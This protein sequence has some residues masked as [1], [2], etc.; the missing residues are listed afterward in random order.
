MAQSFEAWYASLGIV[1]KACIAM[2]LGTALGITVG[3]VNVYSLLL[4][5]SAITSFQVWRFFTAA[6]FFGG[7]SFQ[8]LMTV[9]SFISF[10]RYNEESSFKGKPAD[11]ALAIVFVILVIGLL[12][13]YMGLPV[14]SS[15]LFLAVVWMYC[16]RNP[17]TNLGMFGFDFKA[18]LFPWVLVAVNVLLVGSDILS[19]LL[20]IVAG[21][22]YVFLKDVLPETHN[23]RLLETPLWLQRYFVAYGGQVNTPFGAAGNFNRNQPPPPSQRFFTGKG[24]KLGS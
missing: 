19:N 1:T 11:F 5:S 12:G 7:F 8:W 3:Y 23:L 21:H 4:N 18:S 6:F 20:G 2:V 13:I 22:L 9:F 17:T 15:S 10:L 24:Q 14:T 16:K